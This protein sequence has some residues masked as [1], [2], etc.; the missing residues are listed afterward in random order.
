VPLPPT[1]A[2]NKVKQLRTKKGLTQRQLAE[3]AGT[4]QQ[5]IQRIE[6]GVQAARLEV[7]FG[8]CRALEV[9]ITKIFPKTSKL[10]K[11]GDDPRKVLLDPTR[12]DAFDDAGVD[13]DPTRHILKVW[14]LGEEGPWFF[15][16]TTRDKNRLWNQLQTSGSTATLEP[17]FVVFDTPERRTAL[18]TNYIDAWQFCFEVPGQGQVPDDDEDID[19]E[20]YAV[21]VWVRSRKTPLYFEVNPDSETMNP[22]TDQYEVD[23]ECQL[24]AMFYD[25]DQGDNELGII[26]FMDQDGEDAFFRCDNVV[27]IDVHLGYVEPTMGEDEF[28]EFDTYDGDVP[29]QLPA[30]DQTVN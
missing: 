10:L 30:P 7:A 6:A 15:P 28:E 5:Q 23:G 18:N 21:R 4:T 22:V 14:I 2:P 1:K 8:I 20:N 13:T 27:C 26:T 12:R 16:L 24:Q 9:P 17:E 11:K 29:E 25:L 3:Q 19:H